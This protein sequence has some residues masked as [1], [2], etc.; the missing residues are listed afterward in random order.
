MLKGLFTKNKDKDTSTYIHNKIPEHIAIIMDGNGRWA[1][2]RNMPRLLGH[3]EGV[4]QV[5]NIAL[6]CDKIGV[7]YLTIYAFSTENWNRPK[8]EVSG[9]MDLL[10]VFLKKELQE[11]HERKY[12]FIMLGDISRLPAKSRKAMEDAIE[13]TKDNT[14][15]RLIIAL[16][17]GSRDEI[18]KASK[19]IATKVSIGELNI[20][21]IDETVFSDHLY[22]KGIPDPDLMIRTS[23]EIRLSNYLLWQLA[24]AEFIF[25]EDYWPDFGAVKLNEAIDEY[26]TR[27]RRFGKVKV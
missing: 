10:V 11:M 13:K 21:D 6:E 7:K 8:E 4:K 16:N 5:K 20:S 24:Y 25:V 26:N 19:H 12:K 22:T 23:G 2:E 3:K 18:V 27:N 9:L 17:Y 14:G 1:K 15:L